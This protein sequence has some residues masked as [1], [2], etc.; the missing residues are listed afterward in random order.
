MVS[1][2]KVGE[3]TGVVYLEV[4]D[5]NPSFV[6]SI[7]R[8]VMR[9]V[10]TLAVENVAIYEND[11]VMFDEFVSHRLG[12]LP[13]KSSAKG[14]KPGESLK[15]V[16]EKE[17]PCMVYSKDIKSTDP[18]VEVADK[19]IPIVKLGKGHT[20]KLE[21][22]A[23]MMS[24]KE[25]T[26]WQPAVISYK[27]D[28]KDEKTFTFEIE[29]TGSLTTKELLDKAVSVLQEKVKEFEKELKKVK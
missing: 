8:T 3:E 23:V 6:N 9:D 24:G 21:M 15:L 14:Y 13:I 29:S 7:R 22:T 10:P 26:K 2:K 17:G 11:S 5:T 27:Q 25:H 20:L 28:D 12:M 4:K 18:K 19:K 1:V 16:L